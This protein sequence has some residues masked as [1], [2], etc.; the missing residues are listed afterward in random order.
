MRLAYQLHRG[1]GFDVAMDRAQLWTFAAQNGRSSVLGAA[2]RASSGGRIDVGAP[3]DMVL[4]NWDALDDDNLLPVD[5]LDLLLA[6]ASGMHID[7]VII[8]AERWS[9]REGARRGR[10]CIACRTD[11]ADARAH[12][13]ATGGERMA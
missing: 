10:A 12:R 7:Q 9:P 2:H 13:R 11:R 6:R 4:L 8:G 3:A 1:W 5:P